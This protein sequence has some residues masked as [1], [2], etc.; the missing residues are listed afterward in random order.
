MLYL[1]TPHAKK[2]FNTDL[3]SNILTNVIHSEQLLSRVQTLAVGIT[4]ASFSTFLCTLYMCWG[5][6]ILSSPFTWGGLRARL[7]ETTPQAGPQTGAQSG[8]E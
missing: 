8:H 4:V 1:Q 3:H 2:S 6:G 7:A 5:L